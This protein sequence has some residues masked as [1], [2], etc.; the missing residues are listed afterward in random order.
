MKMNHNTMKH[1]MRFCYELEKQ[2]EYIERFLKMLEN[3][4]VKASQNASKENDFVQ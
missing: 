3:E 2:N 4:F 1:L